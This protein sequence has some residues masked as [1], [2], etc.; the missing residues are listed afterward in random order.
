MFVYWGTNDC[1]KTHM[2]HYAQ[3]NDKTYILWMP[4]EIRKIKTKTHINETT[5]ADETVYITKYHNLNGFR[6]CSKI[7]NRIWED[8]FLKVE[9]AVTHNSSINPSV[10]IHKERWERRGDTDWKSPTGIYSKEQIE[11]YTQ[12]EYTDTMVYFDLISLYNYPIRDGGICDPLTHDCL[13]DHYDEILED[14]DIILWWGT[15]GPGPGTFDDWVLDDLEDV[16]RD[17]VNIIPVKSDHLDSAI[18][19]LDH[20]GNL[21]G[22]NLLEEYEKNKN[23]VFQYL[24]WFRQ[25]YVDDTK[26]ILTQRNIPYQMF[27]LDTD[28]YPD[29]FGWQVDVDRKF[30]H[31]GVSWKHENY[32]RVVEIAKEYVSSRAL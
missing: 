28:S 31:R 18:S 29:T 3:V 9:S 11:K 30:S 26:D 14:V 2:K 4:N 17:S 13:K 5:W 25:K 24:D 6:S 7:K 21:R 32:E 15:F 20:F 23:S 27:D 12:K 8:P 16:L 1:G 10:P 22:L 19:K